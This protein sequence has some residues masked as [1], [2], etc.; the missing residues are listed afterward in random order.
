MN[1][2]LQRGTVGTAVV[3]SGVIVGAALGAFSGVAAATEPS[4]PSTTN[5]AA[6]PSAPSTTDASQASEK[7]PAPEGTR[8]R[9]NASGHSYGSAAYAEQLG[10][11]PDLVRVIMADGNDGYVY[12]SELESDRPDTL[13]E[14]L[15]LAR[16]GVVK[17]EP[18]TAYAADGKTVIGEF[19]MRGDPQL[20]LD[21][22]Q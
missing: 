6:E 22:G 10:G 15:A 9:V 2:K 13:E 18:I 19:P 17:R 16:K 8:Y 20:V 3:A 1:R 5:A 4:A 14:G 11:S 12:E 7:P 21:A